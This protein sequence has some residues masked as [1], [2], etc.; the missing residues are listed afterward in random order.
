MARGDARSSAFQVVVGVV[1]PASQLRLPCQ[2]STQAEAPPICYVL[3]LDWWFG[4]PA[5]SMYVRRAVL[6]RIQKD[7]AWLDRAGGIT[8]AMIRNISLVRTLNMQRLPINAAN[9]P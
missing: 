9:H 4:E 5:K 1:G 7:V 3:L 2:R 6:R 8:D